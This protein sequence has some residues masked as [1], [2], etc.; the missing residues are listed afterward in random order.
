MSRTITLSTPPIRER[1]H[2]AFMERAG[3]TG[4]NLDV[5]AQP[6]TFLRLVP[7]YAPSPERSR[8]ESSALAGSCEFGPRC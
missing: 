6:S 4:G 3:A 1:R 5:Q 2:G 7:C 8:P